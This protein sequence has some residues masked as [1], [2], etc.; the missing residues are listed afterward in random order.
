MNFAYTWMKFVPIFDLIISHHCFRYRLGT[1][2]F[3][4]VY[5]GLSPSMGLQKSTIF[6]YPSVFYDYTQG[7]YVYFSIYWETQSWESFFFSFKIYFFHYSKKLHEHAQPL[8]TDVP[9]LWTIRC[10]ILSHQN[11]KIPISIFPI[12]LKFVNTAT[13]NGLSPNNIYPF[14]ETLPTCCHLL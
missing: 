8:P 1:S 4:D 11:H 10:L 14:S 9:I 12:T 3:T 5:I 13:S 7:N 2:K 6:T